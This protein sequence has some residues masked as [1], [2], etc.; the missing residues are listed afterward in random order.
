MSFDE[1]LMQRLLIVEGDEDK[2]F[3]DNFTPHLSLEDIQILPIGGKTQLR[4]GLGS[5]KNAKGFRNVKFVGI[6]RDADNDP[7]AAF[8]SVRD[9]LKFHKLPYPG[10]LETLCLES[11]REDPA[12]PCVDDYFQCLEKQDLTKPRNMHKARI[13][14]FLASRKEPDKRLGEA[15]QAD[16]W[17][18]DSDVFDPL[19]N[20]LEQISC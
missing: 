3:F 19:K 9:A 14:A 16:I 5:I 6:V 2:M 7:K 4:S 13:H 20:F 10:K 8:Q 17:P 18:F 11:V 15:A 1:I 12:M